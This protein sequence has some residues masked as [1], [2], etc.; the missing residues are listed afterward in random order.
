MSTTGNWNRGASGG[1]TLFELLVVLAVLAIVAVFVVPQLGGP[2]GGSVDSAVRF[3]RGT[4][5]QGRT[6]AKLTRTN[7]LVEFEP[8]LVRI[9][10]KKELDFPASVR[11]RE[12]VLAGEDGD[13]PKGLLINRRGVASS[14]IVRLDTEEGLYSLLVNPVLN[15]VECR[16]GAAGFEDFTE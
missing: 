4:V 15:E 7:V 6:L 13:G 9:A 12:L 2:S 14:A 1:F 3:V 16:P 11:F 10:G 5:G 8:S